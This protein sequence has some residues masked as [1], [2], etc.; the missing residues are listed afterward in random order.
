MLRKNKKLQFS[1]RLSLGICIKGGGGQG[2]RTERKANRKNKKN[3]F[4]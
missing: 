3:R 1:Q 2:A 4:I